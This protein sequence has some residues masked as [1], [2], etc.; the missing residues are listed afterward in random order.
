M[1]KRTHPTDPR[2]DAYF[3]ALKRWHEESV[4]LRATLLEC[5]VDELLKWRKPCYAS[6]G[7]NL[8]I[9][10]PMKGFLALLFFKG[11][12]IKDPAGVLERQGENSES[13]RR[14]CFTDVR[15]V[16]RMK[17]T[18][19]RFVRQ[20]IEIEKS[21]QSVPKKKLVLADELQLRLDTDPAFKAAFDQLTPG[22]RREY[23]LFVCGAKQ[24]KTRTARVDKH[25]ARILAGKGLR[26]R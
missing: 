16:A 9:I 23:N 17:A 12:L 18:V 13:S 7:N 10:Q 1:T 20:A 8:A 21:G 3:A 19:K 25:V 4:L 24:S 14:L 26:D 6:G 2:V 22:R 5:D 11:A 15:Q